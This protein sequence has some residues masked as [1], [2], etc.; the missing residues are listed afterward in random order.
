MSKTI[1]ECDF[2]TYMNHK[3]ID[4]Y[5]SCEII[6]TY[7]VEHNSK[8]YVL[9]EI[10]TK[11]Q[12]VVQKCYPQ[13]WGDEVPTFKAIISGSKVV[14]DLD[15]LNSGKL[16]SLGKLSTYGL[17]IIKDEIVGFKYEKKSIDTSHK[18]YNRPL[19]AVLSS[20]EFLFVN[21]EMCGINHY[22]GEVWGSE[23]YSYDTYIMFDNSCIIL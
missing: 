1:S 16:E 20:L 14:E 8:K 13:T 18:K 6:K 3:Y 21:D 5:D 17:N 19:C 10:L 12:I 2:W 15:N 22:Y 7:V 4:G 9:D 23:Y 11:S